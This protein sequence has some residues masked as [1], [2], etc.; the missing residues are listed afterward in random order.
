M[1]SFPGIGTGEVIDWAAAITGPLMIK[2]TSTAFYFDGTTAVG[3]TGTGTSTSTA[4]SYPGTTVPGLQ[5]L[6]GTFYVMLPDGTIHNSSG[7]EDDPRTWPTDGFISAQFEPD[8][9]VFLGKALSYIVAFGQWTTELFWDAGNPTASPLSPVQN[10]VLLIGCA[11]ARSV[12][13][14]EST[15]VWVAQRKG[16]NSTNQKGRFVAM[17]VGT[18][19]KELST[20]DISRVLDADSLVGVRSCIIELGGHSWYVLALPASNI[21]L[22]YDF[23]SG[24]W[25]VWT[26]LAAGTPVTISGIT[27]TNGLVTATA[28]SHGIS[29]GDPAVISGVT[30]TGFNGT[31][32]LSVNTSS[33]TFQY[34]LSTSGTTTGTGA[35][36][37]VTP[38]TESAFAMVASLGYNG[39]QVV[40]DTSGNVYTLSLSTALDDGSIP[41]NW[42]VRT[43]NLDQ[44]N[45]ERKFAHSVAIIADIA[46][47]GTGMLRYTDNDYQSYG[48]FRRFDMSQTR[49]N[50]Q[51]WGN[52]RRRAWEWRYT[53][54]ERLRVKELEMSLEQ[55]DT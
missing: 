26:R 14:T 32:N 4:V 55:G 6:D 41:I 31:F 20:P 18:S 28:S 36:K 24:Q 10:G 40:M 22:V 51:R 54:R 15:L 33:H 49:V 38:Y 52:F 43:Q 13:Q 45:N 17:L 47:T 2:G 7:A 35:S 50:Q 42:R 5:Y 53:D 30:P 16:Q 39:Q 46:G 37:Q 9:G 12:A 21:T 8:S 11:A 19:Y 1:P 3:I 27:Q 23:K 44:G 48:Y 29:D 34:P 25:Y